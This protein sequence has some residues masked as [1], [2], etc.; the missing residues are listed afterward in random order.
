L[1]HEGVGKSKV[2]QPLVMTLLAYCESKTVVE[3]QRYG[4]VV[5]FAVFTV[6]G[7]AEARSVGVP[8][9]GL[10]GAVFGCHCVVGTEIV[11]VRFED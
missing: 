11:V 3:A 4:L 2:L 10:L 5:D 8:G 9:I 6:A 7:L 1:D